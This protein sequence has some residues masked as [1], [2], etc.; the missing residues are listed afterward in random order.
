MTADTVRSVSSVFA[1]MFISVLLVA[2][3]TSTVLVA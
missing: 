2:A 1:A 3:S